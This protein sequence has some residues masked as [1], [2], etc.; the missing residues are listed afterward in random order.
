M[1]FPQYRHSISIRILI[2]ILT[3]ASLLLLFP[4]SSLNASASDSS[5]S[6]LRK[7]RVGYYPLSNFQEYD[8]TTGSYRGYSYD[9]MLALAQYA[10]WEYE[11][12]PCTYEEGL[13]MLEDGEIDLMN[14]IE[15]T[16]T[17][18]GKLYFS[19]IPSG[20]SCTCLMVSPDNTDI[21]YDDFASFSNITVGLDYTNS[22]NSQF[23]DYCKDNDCLP[24][25]IYYHS[26]DEV[27][28]AMD[29]GQIDAYLVSSLE[30][31]NMRTIAKFGTV[32]Y[33]FATTKGNSDLL[34]ELNSAMNSLTTNDTYFEEKTYAKYHA[35]SSEQQTV[36]SNEEKAYIAEN[37]VVTVSYDPYWYPISYKNSDGKFDGAMAKIFSRIAERTGLTFE[38]SENNTE[39]ATLDAFKNGET[40]VFAGF[41]Y[42]YTWALQQ[43][44]R[45]TTP[46]TTVTVFAAY[47]TGQDSGNR[48]ALP[49]GSYQQYLSSQIHL[50]SYDYVN[51]DTPEECLNAVQ[52]GSASYALLNSYQ[53][54]YYQERAKYRDL[55]YKVA[56][57]ED[58]QLSIA[59]SAASDPL[60]YSIIS[61]SLSA[62]GTDEITE[63]F[64]ETSLTAESRSLTDILYANPKTAV[65]LFLLLGFFIAAIISVLVYSSSMNKKNLELK[66]A[67]S[68]KSDFLSNMS[69]DMRT[70]LNGIIGYTNLALSSDRPEQRQDYLDKI[71]I[72]GQF[73][74]TLI[75]DTLDISKIESGKYVLSPEAVNTEE[76]LKSITVPILS[77]AGEKHIKFIISTDKMYH[78]YIRADR[79]GIQKIVLNL[80]SNAVKFTP[81]G[82]TVTLIIENYPTDPNGRNA[83]ISVIDT[84]IGIGGDFLPAIFEPFTQEHATGTG[85]IMGTGLGLSI[86]K[87]MIDLM[88]GTI[89]VESRRGH[90]SQFIVLLPVEILENY[91]PA[92]SPD[93]STDKALA[94]KKIL[95]CE[96]ND[97]N[98]EIAATLLESKGIEATTAEN[99]RKGLEC[100]LAS[101]EGTFDGILM[102][103]RMPDMNGYEAA[104]AI[105]ASGRSDS[106]S[107]PIIAMTA[108]AYAEDIRKCME[109]GMN[110]HIAKPVDPE[111]LFTELKKYCTKKP[112]ET[113]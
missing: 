74:L 53:M 6:S 73:L 110:S 111:I 29:S 38:F 20:T 47:K 11:F 95:L 19:T 89:A 34:L 33:Y 104:A 3:A 59:T 12:V 23:V 7:V 69:H 32:S 80:L 101:P 103:L 67:A 49:S 9:Y 54:E 35:K 30:D 82:G 27:R 102:D 40:Q 63:I 71:R 99:G 1:R 75:N 44:A 15:K 28:N 52:N 68:A 66:A 58:Y 96:D 83:R 100:F 13:Q 8:S 93:I 60:L 51:Y 55:S 2:F 72:S 41:P 64:K 22:H 46:F 10:G 84:G 98:T 61:K 48:A 31:V 62:I 87:Y 94:G 88:G 109:C 16:S 107:V 18:S 21:A 106:A 85:N 108:D 70:P 91:K 39:A 4:A 17:L 76:L 26:S 79:L 42:D 36:L 86:V 25:L 105:R 112:E 14:N 65:I 56:A 24:R 43:N 92:A 113:E 90:G 57:G 78:G 5:E 45:V 77:A 37:P 50:D 97:M 81:E